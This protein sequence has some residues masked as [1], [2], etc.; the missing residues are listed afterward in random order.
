MSL[1]KVRRFFGICA[2]TEVCARTVELFLSGATAE[3]SWEMLVREGFGRKLAARSVTLI[4]S[5]FARVVYE[6]EGIKFPDYFYPGAKAYQEKMFT[7]YSNEPVFRAA[8]A[9]AQRMQSARETDKIMR[10]VE[11]S[12]EHDAIMKAKAQGLT[13]SDFSFL[14]HEF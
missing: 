3:R 4:P 5:A 7:R 13:P 8:L 10:I 14:I 9:L 12:T 1:A 11:L 2:A 6:S